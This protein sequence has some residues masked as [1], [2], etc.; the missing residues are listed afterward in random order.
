M[1][2]TAATLTSY[3][4]ATLAFQQTAV[5]ASRPRWLHNRPAS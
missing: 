1:F 4:Q 5:T 3:Q 2:D